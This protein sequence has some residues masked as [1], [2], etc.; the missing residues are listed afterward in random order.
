MFYAFTSLIYAIFAHKIES[1]LLSYTV[2]PRFLYKGRDL[3]LYTKWS[4]TNSCYCYLRVA[5]RLVV[6]G[7]GGLVVALQVLQAERVGHVHGGQLAGRRAR[8][9]LGR[10]PA[11]QLVVAAARAAR[12]AQLCNTHTTHNTPPLTSLA[13]KLR[14]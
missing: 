9:Q 11:R 5:A 6:H 3:I 13:Y 10:E 12:R 14:L 8:Q 4:L 1:I 7:R 2:L